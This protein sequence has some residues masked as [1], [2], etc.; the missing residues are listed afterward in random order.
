M[1]ERGFSGKLPTATYQTRIRSFS[2]VERAASCAPCPG[3]TEHPGSLPDAHALH[4][5]RPANP[6]V[7]VHHVHP[8]HHP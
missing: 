3:A 7:Y 6:Q 2:D 8:S 1:A 5:H 4:H